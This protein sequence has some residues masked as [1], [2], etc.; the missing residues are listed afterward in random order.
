MANDCHSVVQIVGLIRPR[1]G[2]PGLRGRWR[3]SRGCPGRCRHHS[4]FLSAA[5]IRPN[6]PDPAA[7]TRR[8]RPTPE[9]PAGDAAAAIPGS[10]PAPGPPAGPGGSAM[11]QTPLPARRSKS[12][13]E[14]GS[15]SPLARAGHADVPG[16]VDPPSPVT[17]GAGLGAGSHGARGVTSAEC[18]ALRSHRHISVG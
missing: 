7:S 2:R 18:S 5:G 8:A 3:R 1:S 14:P 11:A 15:G 6:T 10:A 9:S 4:S 13:M 12:I 17:R 16:W